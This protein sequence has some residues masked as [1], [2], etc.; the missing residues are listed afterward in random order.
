MTEQDIMGHD[1]LTSTGRL[2]P[3]AALT[4]GGNVSV[5][6][7]GATEHVAQLKVEHK[8][9]FQVGGSYSFKRD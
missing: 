6:G 1:G 7:C 4:S 3:P 2:V 5:P 8:Q 9:D